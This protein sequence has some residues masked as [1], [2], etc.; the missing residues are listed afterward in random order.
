MNAMATAGAPVVNGAPTAA[1]EGTWVEKVNIL[2]PNEH[3]G[4]VIGARG[5]GLQHL[6]Q[7]SGAGI[8]VDRDAGPTGERYVEITGRPDQIML[9]QALIDQVVEA[10]EMAPDG[11]PLVGLKRKEAD[12]PAVAFSP[13]ARGFCTSAQG[14][15][16]AGCSASNLAHA[17]FLAHAS[18]TG[19]AAMSA[20][21][22]QHQAFGGGYG[23]AGMLAAPA[24]VPGLDARLV[25]ENDKAGI[26]IG[27]G[28]SGL[29]ELRKVAR[30]LT[31]GRDTIAGLSEGR[32]L[33]IGPPA[34]SQLRTIAMLCDK[35]SANS[36][37]ASVGLP[38]TALKLLVP[39]KHV[40]A[41]VGKGGSGL[42]HIRQQGVSVELDRQNP[43]TLFVFPH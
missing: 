30:S 10:A 5:A 22:P 2:V 38:A 26:V 12:S 7:E 9:V 15:F 36:A 31:L 33:T 29:R 8:K 18:M 25:I 39:A 19:Q 23:L 34:A 11:Q 32:L 20:S 24:A 21:P 14:G 16:V 40:G 41:I 35:L 13:N 43:H 17:S 1:P 3:I 6:R 42:Q 28:G 37:G 4:R 27:K